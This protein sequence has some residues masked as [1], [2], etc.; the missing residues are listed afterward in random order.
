LAQAKYASLAGRGHIVELMAAPALWLRRRSS[1]SGL[2]TVALV[3]VVVAL[4][5]AAAGRPSAARTAPCFL[6]PSLAGSG[7]DA[8]PVASGGRSIRH[9]ELRA[10][11]SERD[12]AAAPD[13]DW[14]RPLRTLLL[15]RRKN[16]R[17]EALKQLQGVF[18]SRS[19]D[20]LAEI[21]R[22]GK[23]SSQRGGL[24]LRPFFGYRAACAALYRTMVEH[25]LPAQ[26]GTS[27]VVQ[28][29]NE[30]GQK[31]LRYVLRD[32]ATEGDEEGEG[33]VA[34]DA[35][36]AVEKQMATADT[37]SRARALFV[38]LRQLP[39]STAWALEAAAAESNS[40]Q[41][42]A[43]W[44]ERTPDLETP[45]YT[46]LSRDPEGVYEVRKYDAYS[47]VETDKKSKD[48]SGKGGGNS[49]F[50]ALANYIFGKANVKQEKMAMT[51]PVQMD[52]RSGTMSFI[53]PSNYWGADRLDDAPAPADGAGVRLVARD[54]EVIAVTTFGGY[55]RA[56]AVAERKKKLL[57]ALARAA[58]VEVPDQEAVRV[59]QYNDP[60][61]V[62]WKRR[63]EV[64]VP[65]LLK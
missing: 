5:I 59:M 11:G 51:T 33:D 55:A 3:A 46:V 50:F 25:V 28:R 18:E 42:E 35:S 49:Q 22:Y 23:D 27:V 26:E 10:Q 52:Q 31:R 34:A 15:A 16:V 14:R 4:A 12:V 17:L 53:M 60:F 7:R 30:E 40:E 37:A 38:I 54:E 2:L 62:P 47:A 44:N 39:G 43:K 32:D 8:L 29:R 61:T 65:V 19:A 58:D 41:N 48:E 21:E 20:I 57:E 13:S 63:N 45:K 24:R 6:G 9:S 64:S 36:E 1:R 56:P